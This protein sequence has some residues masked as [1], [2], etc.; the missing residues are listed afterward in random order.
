MGWANQTRL[1][2]LQFQQLKATIGQGLINAFTPVLQVINKLLAKLQ[3]LAEAFR[4]LTVALFGDA[5]SGSAGSGVSSLGDAYNDAA[6][7]AGNLADGIGEVGAAAKKANKQ[8]LNFDELNTLAEPDK[9]TGAGG[10]VGGG[11]DMGLGELEPPDL[12]GTIFDPERI[13]KVADTIKKIAEYIPVMVAG[14]AGLKLGKFISQLVFAGKKA[15]TLKE[16]IALIGKKAALIGGITL[17]VTGLAFETKGIIS[18]IKD[19][20]NKINFAEIVGGGSAIA[21]GGALI[22]SVF[23]KAVLGGA[24]GGIVAGVPAFFAGVYDAFKNG[25]DLLSASLIAAGATATG[26]GIGA[27]IGSLGGPIGAGVGALIGLIV[28]AITDLGILI[29]QQWDVISAWISNALESIGNWFSDLWGKVVEVWNIAANWFNDNVTEPVKKFFSDMW[30]E[31][32]SFASNAWYDVKSIYGAVSG[33]LRSNLIDPVS[34]LFSNL[35]DGFVNGARSAWEGI[36]GVFSSFAGW[37]RK[38]FEDAWRGIVNVFSVGGEIFVSIKDGIVSAFK[39]V[40]NSLIRGINDVVAIPFNGINTA[41]SAIREVNILGLRPFSG[42]GSISVP[43][44]P[45]LAKGAV[46]PPNAPFMAMLGDQKNGTN[47][48]APLS[49]IQEA[50]LN[51]LEQYGGRGQ[52]ININFTGDLAQLA[53]ILKPEIDQENKRIG[54]SLARG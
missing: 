10:A 14:L 45:Y 24:I 5:S 32:V 40:V 18:S 15:D 49:T 7:G 17:T 22:G 48:E 38:I 12:T 41:L 16:K 30:D 53:R 37:F 23:G 28:G 42:I 36:K 44:I 47:I 50:L 3:V 11:F 54:V 20:L 6:L 43:H 35:W 26:A 31:I 21:A 19:G 52:E 25:I 27:I 39:R 9:G 29:Y 46:I 13:Q 51:A 4:Q 8:L 34:N 33:W 1:L 2:S